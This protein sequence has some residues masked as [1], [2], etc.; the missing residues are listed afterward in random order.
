MPKLIMM[1]K[2]CKVVFVQCQTA[3][4]SNTQGKHVRSAVLTLDSLTNMVERIIRNLQTIS[5]TV[6]IQKMCL[7]PSNGESSI[8]ECCK[9]DILP[10]STSFIQRPLIGFIQSHPHQKLHIFTP[11]NQCFSSRFKFY[12]HKPKITQK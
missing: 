9:T 2:Y 6:I 5:K 8:Q 12:I 3:V 10:T 4:K 11:K 1:S 7:A